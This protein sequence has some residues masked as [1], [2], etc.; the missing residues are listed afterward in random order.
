MFPLSMESVLGWDAILG[1]LANAIGYGQYASVPES[2]AYLLVHGALDH[3][4]KGDGNKRMAASAAAMQCGLNRYRISCP[5]DQLAE[6]VLE[7]IALRGNG[8]DIERI[9]GR[10]AAWF[11]QNI[12]P[13]TSIP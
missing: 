1:S 4:I 2:A 10:V 13:I 11:E 6:V 9:V 3:P 7:A 8:L 12:E 5:H